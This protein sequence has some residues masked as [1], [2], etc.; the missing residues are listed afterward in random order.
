MCEA[1]EP[2]HRLLAH[3]LDRQGFLLGG[4]AGGERAREAGGE[5]ARQGIPSSGVRLPSAIAAVTAVTAPA[6]RAG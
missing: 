6:V 2:P 5:H 4:S 1:T 3:I